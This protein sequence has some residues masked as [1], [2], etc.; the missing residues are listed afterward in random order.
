M[1]IYEYYCHHCHKKFEILQS[2]SA[3]PLKDCENCHEPA[4]EKLMSATGFQLKGTGWY[5]TDFKNKPT[6]KSSAKSSSESTESK[7]DSTTQSNAKPTSTDT[8]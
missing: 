1:P 7:T 4:L 6:E 2:M 5:V 8:E 3:E